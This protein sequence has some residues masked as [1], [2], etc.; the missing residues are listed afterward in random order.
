MF[1]WLCNLLIRYFLCLLLLGF[2]DFFFGGFYL[3]YLLWVYELWLMGSDM[4]LMTCRHS[5]CWELNLFLFVDLIINIWC[6]SNTSHM[7]PFTCLKCALTLNR[8]D[9]I[10]SRW[11]FRQQIVV[12]AYHIQVNI[13]GSF[14]LFLFS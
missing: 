13:N 9:F 14:F 8:D 7:K 2:G 11:E 6:L 10:E 5:I 3:Y 12:T 1:Y 4:C